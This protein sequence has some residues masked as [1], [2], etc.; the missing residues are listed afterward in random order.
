MT[1]DPQL[2]AQGTERGARSSEQGAGAQSSG[3]R[4]QGSGLRAQGVKL[5]ITRDVFLKKVI[6]IGL[7]ALLSIIS[8]ALAGKIAL[9]NNCSVCP[10]KGICNG[11]TDCNKY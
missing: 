11:K 10:G 6:R 5:V 8:F 2:K 9:G 3:L 7:L 4:A 1:L